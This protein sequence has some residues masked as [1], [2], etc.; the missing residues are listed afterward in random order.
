MIGNSIMKELRPAS[1]LFEDVRKTIQKTLTS[2][3]LMIRQKYPKKK[4]K[5]IS[6]F[7]SPY[8][9]SASERIFYVL[10]SQ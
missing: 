2:L 4:S 9:L 1:L 8:T 6:D 5:I 7:Q 3:E 10:N